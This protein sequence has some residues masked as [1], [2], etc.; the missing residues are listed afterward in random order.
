ML[1]IPAPNLGVLALITV[2]LFA[3]A[4][5]HAL[6]AL[7]YRVLSGLRSKRQ[8]T[9]RSIWDPW[10]IR[11]LVGDAPASEVHRHVGPK[12]RIHFVAALIRFA[13][14]LAGD[15]RDKVC[16]LAQPYLG[17]VQQRVA[18]RSPATR[19]RAVQTLGELGWPEYA[20]AVVAGLDDRSP[21]VAMVAA[22]ML[23]RPQA[24]EYAKEV[25]ARLD[26]FATWTPMLLASMLANTGPEIATEL[27]AALM[28]PNR[29]SHVRVSA[30]EALRQL[31]D[32]DS[33]NDAVRVLESEK[34]REVLAATLR[35]VGRVG[36]SFH[37]RSVAEFIDN[38]DF[39]IRVATADA[40]AGL[41]GPN[42]LQ[43]LR[44]ILVN[45]PSQWVALRAARS[46]LTAGWREEL[47]E[48]ARSEHVRAPIAAQVLAEAGVL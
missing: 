11:H 12:H 4:L 30:A 28:D 27:R 3:L 15:E 48:L 33:A 23:C 40:L 8:Q 44:R 47:G 24:A 10:I 39:V 5:I 36:R 26:R 42:E 34:D 1:V 13:R 21:L 31:N 29:P 46:L 41:G 14:R 35:L 6:L 43:E 17:V 19:A 20:P 18:S 45:D 38:P 16:E 22:Q 25:V 32:F 37:T 7:N 9:L 2:A